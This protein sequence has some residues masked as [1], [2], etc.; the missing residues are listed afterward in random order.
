VVSATSSEGFLARW[1]INS[2]INSF[3]YSLIHSQMPHFSGRVLMDPGIVGIKLGE[4]AATQGQHRWQNWQNMGLS[5]WTRGSNPQTPGN[6]RTGSRLAGCLLV[7]LSPLVPRENLPQNWIGVSY[8]R[9]VVVPGVPLTEPTVPERRV[10]LRALTTTGEIQ[11]LT[12][13]VLVSP[14]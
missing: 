1:L 5:T 11:A 2:L 14:K 4:C 12:S 10:E 8:Y 7:F 3:I 6:F 13:F 9:P